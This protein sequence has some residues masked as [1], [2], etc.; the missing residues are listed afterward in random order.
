LQ[1]TTVRSGPPPN[2]TAFVGERGR[3]ALIYQIEFVRDV[4][5]NEEG[6]ISALL[7]SANNRAILGSKTQASIER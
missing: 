6:M 7:A 5:E 2:R 1:D 3:T 4:Q